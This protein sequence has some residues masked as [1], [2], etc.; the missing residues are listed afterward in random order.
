[1]LG[2]CWWFEMER[3]KHLKSRPKITPYPK[4]IQSNLKKK[5]IKKIKSKFLPNN[6]IIKIILIGN[7]I[8]NTF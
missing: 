4:T 7:I 1:M 5:A 2:L 6:K 8:K 3:E